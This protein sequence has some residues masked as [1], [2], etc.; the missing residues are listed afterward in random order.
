[1]DSTPLEWDHDY[2]LSRDLQSASQT[3]PSEDK[4]SYLRGAVG[5]SDVVIPKNPKA[6]VKPTENTIGNTCGAPSSLE[7]Q[8]RQ[9]DK[10]LDASRFQMQQI[11]SEAKFPQGQTWTPAYKGYMKLLGECNGSIDLVRRLAHKLTE[12]ENLPGFVNLNSAAT[13]TAAVNDRWE[14]LQAQA[15]SK[16]LRV[17]QSL[18]KRQQFNSD[19]N[20]IWAWLGKTEEEVDRLQ[21]L[22]LSTDIRTIESRI[23]KLRELQ[24]AI[25]HHEAINLSIG[26]CS[27]EFTQADS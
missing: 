9:L 15:M 17:K 21:P 8:M 12:E 14:L 25:D 6:Y 20:G 1:M 7:S 16:K 5:L 23:R 2:D 27:S 3:L 18:R 19:C 26:L 10:A 4:E 11:S 22:A 24:K 13:Q